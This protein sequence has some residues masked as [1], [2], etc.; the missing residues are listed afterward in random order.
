MALKRWNGTSWE[1]YVEGATTS[2]AH[3]GFHDS[4]QTD[5]ILGR[6]VF[7][8][9]SGNYTV[10]ST[11]AGVFRCIS[12]NSSSAATVTL[13]AYSTVPFAPGTVVNI[14]QSGAGKVTVSGV[15]GVTLNAPIGATTAG[16]GG[17]IVLTNLSANVWAVNGNDSG[18]AVPNLVGLTT[19][20]A[21]AALT[22][23]RLTKGTATS[24]YTSN[25]A[26]NL[27]VTSQSTDA[28]S[29]VV[30]NTPISYAYTTYLATPSTPNL[31]Y[32]GSQGVFKISNYNSAYLYAVTAGTISGDT[33]T[34]P[35]ATSEAYISAKSFSGG[36]SSPSR[37]YANHSADYTADT[38][39]SYACGT[40]CDTCQYCHC[41]TGAPCD[42]QSWGQCGCPGA[43]CWY[44]SYS[45]NC[46][47]NYCSGGSAPSLIDQP[48]YT[49]NGSNEWYKIV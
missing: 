44:G 22:A 15:P 11:D 43:M 23:G 37:Y 17:I 16:Q 10:A 14:L 7:N 24:S 35:G 46:R 48:G 39:Y 47:T 5:E 1:V 8:T 6:L 12:V 33:V 38:R 41:G 29:F 34:L 18:V 28:G 30:I 36:D 13:P 27:K 45:C 20:A 4:G 19:A 9:Q 3:S 42:G 40:S 25:S 31:T 21:D 26:L 32:Y 2:V 49:W